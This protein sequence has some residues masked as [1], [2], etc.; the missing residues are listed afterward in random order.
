MAE[1][2]ENKENLTIN[3]VP[4]LKVKD[5]ENVEQ[6]KKE[7]EQRGLKTAMG[8]EKWHVTN[9]SHILKN[10]LKI[11]KELKLHHMQYFK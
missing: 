11:K 6:I 1:L 3:Y 9:I 2:S 7:L 8:K 10:T 5:F 4:S